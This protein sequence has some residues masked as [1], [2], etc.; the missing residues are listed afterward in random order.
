MAIKGIFFDN[1][2]VNAKDFG[3]FASAYGDVFL[4]DHNYSINN[5]VL[6]IPSGYL[7]V[8]GRLIKFDGNQTINLVPT[9]T[10]GFGRI[11]LTVDLT[12]TSTE[13]EFSQVTLTTEFATT[14]NGFNDLTQ[15]DINL[16]GS[17][18]QRD[19]IHIWVN[20]GV[21]YINDSTKGRSIPLLKDITEAPHSFDNITKG[22]L[23]LNSNNYGAT[24]PTGDI[25][26]GTIF[27]KIV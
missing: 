8:G 26:D 27:F 17:I 4:G 21:C 20:N 10:N 5:N 23:R 3:A 18:Y 16:N 6:T 22:T 11:V 14:L 2:V 12:R 25:P 24:L 19:I 1:Q 13:S 7:V 9:I 15:T